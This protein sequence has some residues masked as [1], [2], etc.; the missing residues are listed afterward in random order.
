MT[1]S[2]TCQYRSVHVDTMSSQFTNKV[3]NLPKEFRGRMGQARAKLKELTFL[4]RLGVLVR[5]PNLG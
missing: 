3:K 2:K 1:L 4:A 5:M